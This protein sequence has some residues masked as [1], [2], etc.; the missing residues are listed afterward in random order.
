M[1]ILFVIE[2]RPNNKALVVG[3]LTRTDSFI[4]YKPTASAM[5]S[6]SMWVAYK[7]KEENLPMPISQRIF[8]PYNQGIKNLLHKIQLTEYDEWEVL[9]RTKGISLKDSIKFINRKTLENQFCERIEVKAGSP[10]IRINSDAVKRATKIAEENSE[11]FTSILIKTTMLSQMVK[12]VT[13]NEDIMR[14]SNNLRQA[15]VS[16]SILDQFKNISDKFFKLPNSLVEMHEATRR[17]TEESGIL[18]SF[19]SISDQINDVTSLLKNDAL[20]IVEN[21]LIRKSRL[22]L[23]A[24]EQVNKFME[25]QQRI[26]RQLEVFKKAHKMAQYHLPQSKFTELKNAKELDIVKHSKVVKAKRK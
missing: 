16:P 23:P 21:D 4:E 15:G 9:K 17:I 12:G 11:V 8:S 7:Y 26:N 19:R 3:R 2:V 18:K 5:Q 20:H 24:V 10:R 13:V 6:R 22:A 14:L 25:S 1:E